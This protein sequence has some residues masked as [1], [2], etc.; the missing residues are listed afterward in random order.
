[1]LFRSAKPGLT[2]LK[3][4]YVAGSAVGEPLHLALSKG[5]F[6]DQGFDVSIS[7]AS[8]PA[9]TAA[10]TSGQLPFIAMG[11][12]ELVDSAKAGLQPVMLASL[13]DYPVFSLY[14]AKDIKTMPQLA[15]KTVGMGRPG[16]ATD[17]AAHLFLE[18]YG[19]LDKVKITPV[20]GSSP[21]VFAALESAKIDAGIL[22]PPGTATAAR[23][24]FVELVNGPKLKIPWIHSGVTTTKSYLQQHPDVVKRFMAAVEKSW[25]FLGDPANRTAVV[26]DIAAASKVSSADAS[27]S[28]DYL[29]PVWASKKAPTVDRAGIETAIESADP[30]ARS[31]KPE[32]LFDNTVINAV[33]GGP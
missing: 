33:A 21:A 23:E 10:L 28:Y 4:A 1:M 20:G 8:G 18:K 6:A 12:P 13:A 32:D 27:A 15:G 22:S 29:Y 30:A 19:L 7:S 2:P 26:A 5:L 14:A 17:V 9:R 31:I 16:T 3:I 24:G 11:S 25:T